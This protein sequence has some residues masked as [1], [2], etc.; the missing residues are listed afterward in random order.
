MD[1]SDVQRLL[2]GL[3]DQAIVY[4][5]FA[6]YM[7]DYELYVYCVFRPQPDVTAETVR[8]VF[9]NCVVANAET[10]LTGD[11]WARSLDDQLLHWPEPDDVDGY[12]WGV[13]WQH[14]EN[15]VVVSESPAASGWSKSV[16]IRFHEVRIVTNG[17]NLRLVFSDLTSS[18]VEPGHSPFTVETAGSEPTSPWG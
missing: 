2:D 3:I 16:G 5:G 17:H 13:K 12:V 15:G 7:R 9:K 11:I 8:L 10:A 4:H 6:D 14:F 1:A 18:V